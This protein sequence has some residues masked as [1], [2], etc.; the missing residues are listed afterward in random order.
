MNTLVLT[1]ISKFMLIGSFSA[2]LSFSSKSNELIRQFFFY[3]LGG[4]IV[5][6]I[7]LML[8]EGRDYLLS[9]DATEEQLT[10]IVSSLNNTTPK[11]QY[12]L[13]AKTRLEIV[14]TFVVIIVCALVGAI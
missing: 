12:Y 9:N 6:F 2:Y 13:S 5:T 7:L 3:V 11:K 4:T 8:W 14:L 10:T 1:K